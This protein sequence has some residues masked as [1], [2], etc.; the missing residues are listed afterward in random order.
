MFTRAFF[1]KNYYGNL[2]IVYSGSLKFYK[3]LSVKMKKESPKKF[4]LPKT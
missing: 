2:E 3:V 1:I 4:E